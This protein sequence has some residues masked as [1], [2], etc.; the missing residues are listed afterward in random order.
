MGRCT[1]TPEQIV[2][3][4]RKIEVLVASG[5]AAALACKEADIAEQTY[6]RWR[7]DYGGL[8]LD[9]AKWMKDL[10]RENARL[11]RWVADL[12]L[13]RQVP[14]DIASGSLWRPTGLGRQ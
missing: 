13:E 11:K 5:K 10:E 7:K 1:F 4:L 14:K 12:S 9:L 8:E 3:K 6:C 2:A